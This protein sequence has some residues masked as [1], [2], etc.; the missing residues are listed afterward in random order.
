MSAQA[1]GNEF[2][3]AVVLVTGGGGSCI[4]GPTALRFAQEGANLVICDQHERRNWEM[5]EHIRKQTG[6]RVLDFHLD[7][8]DR[9]KVDAMIAETE[10]EL[11]RVDVL[12]CNAAENKLGHMVDYDP[13]D[14][15][16]TIDVSLNANFYLARKVLPGMVA[17]RRGNIV[18][19][20]SVAGWIG[21]PNEQEGEPAYAVAKAGLLALTRNIAHEVGPHGIR[22]NAVAPGLIWS[23]FVEKFQDQFQ[24]LLEKTPL[25]CFGQSEDIVE[26]ILFLASD[27]RSRFITGEA[28]NVSGGWYM[29]P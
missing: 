24:P 23:R 3:G 2:D 14:W 9:P 4:G 13:A 22:C 10:R 28:L 16:R 15:D 1:T 18:N 19:I 29:R 26:A 6:A 20:A 21:N 5:A 25:R 8:A 11:G 7:I 12:I 17:R 27:K